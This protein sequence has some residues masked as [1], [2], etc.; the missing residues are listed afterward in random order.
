LIER[1]EPVPPAKRT[2]K[3]WYTV[4]ALSYGKNGTVEAWVKIGGSMYR[5]EKKGSGNIRAEI[6]KIG[7]TGWEWTWLGPRRK[8]V[9]IEAQAYAKV[10][11]VPAEAGPWY[12]KEEGDPTHVRIFGGVA[13]AARLFE[14]D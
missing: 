5:D 1:R 11:S 4:L 14:I 6:L 12:H 7:H 3:G 10:N 8:S 9:T 2:V 13:D